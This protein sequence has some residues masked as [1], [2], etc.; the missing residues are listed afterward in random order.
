MWT[1]GRAEPCRLGLGPHDRAGDDRPA[2]PTQIR[3]RPV[4]S[5]LATKHRA[6]SGGQGGRSGSRATCTRS[7]CD[8]EPRRQQREPGLGEPAHRLTGRLRRY[9]ARDR[10]ATVLSPE[11]PAG[12]SRARAC[13]PE[14]YLHQLDERGSYTL[15]VSHPTRVNQRRRRTIACACVIAASPLPARTR[16]LVSGSPHHGRPC[17]AEAA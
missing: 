14:Y 6:T 15:H 17:M 2:A 1:V 8:D 4:H 11:S 9:R 7:Q 12:T 16:E 10:W 13:G 3:L 5:T